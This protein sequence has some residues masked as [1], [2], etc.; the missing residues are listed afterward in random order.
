MSDS[1][2]SVH[3][4]ISRETFISLESFPTTL[5]TLYPR[6]PLLTSSPAPPKKNKRE[7]EGEPWNNW[8]KLFNICESS[9]PLASAVP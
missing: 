9:L 3:A 5:A 8:G 1:A 7:K 6:S 2:E 4:H